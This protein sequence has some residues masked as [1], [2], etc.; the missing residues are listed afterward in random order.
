MD[1]LSVLY[2][3]GVYLGHPQFWDM[4]DEELADV[5][6]FLVEK[7]LP[8][9]RKFAATFADEA[10][11]FGNKEIVIAWGWTGV[12]RAAL[13][14]INIDYVTEHVITPAMPWYVD[15]ISA[16]ADSPNLAAV[17]AWIDYNLLPDVAAKRFA[18]QGL[19]AVEPDAAQYMTAEQQAASYLTP[20]KEAFWSQLDPNLQ[21]HPVPRRA[22]YQQVWNSVKAGISEFSAA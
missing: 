12:I 18:L 2:T 1:D 17:N 8:N 16:V 11:L 3:A 4:T 14:A 6:K 19:P 5:Q 22:L 13:Q 15:T 9:V 7:F 21:W 10:N 20:E